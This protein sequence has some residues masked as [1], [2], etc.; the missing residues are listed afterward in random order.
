MVLS[1]VEEGRVVVARRRPLF[2]GDVL[3]D[4]GAE[5]SP[6]LPRNSCLFLQLKLPENE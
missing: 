6:L 5:Y 1:L 2:E 4:A 3:I